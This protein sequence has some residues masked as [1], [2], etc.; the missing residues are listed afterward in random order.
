VKAVE[1]LAGCLALALVTGVSVARPVNDFPF[2]RSYTQNSQCKGDGSDP[3]ERLVKLSSKTIDSKAGI[4]TF[5]MIKREGSVVAAQVE[6]NFPSGPLVGDVI[7]TMR[8]DNTI[9]FTDRDQNYR[10]VLYRC[11]D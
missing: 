6:C 8:A 1:P 10:S 11:P 7:F 9:N 4:C 3:S 5:L 2:T